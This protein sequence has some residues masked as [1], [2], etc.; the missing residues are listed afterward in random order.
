M[1]MQPELQV[2]WTRAGTPLNRQQLD[3][4]NSVVAEDPWDHLAGAFNDY[5][6]YPYKNVTVRN[7]SV[8]GSMT[9]QAA[10][11]MEALARVCYELN[12][13]IPTRPTR[14]GAWL[15]KQWNTMRSTLTAIRQKYKASGNQDASDPYDE[16]VKFAHNYGEVYCY[17]IAVITLGSIDELGRALP[18]AAQRDTAG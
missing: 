12:P 7:T 1:F 17:A 11:G 16:W 8:T 5:D 4:R 14:D 10:S 3:V 9:W 15:K 2:Y 13:C 18:D 6:K